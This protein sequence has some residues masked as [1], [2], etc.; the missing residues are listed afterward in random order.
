MLAR[1]R[2]LVTPLA[3]VAAVILVYMENPWFYPKAG[4]TENQVAVRIPLIA[5]ADTMLTLT[6]TAPSG[7]AVS[8]ATFYYGG[9]LANVDTAVYPEGTFDVMVANPTTD[10][11][12]VNIVSGGTGG[13]DVTVI[14]TTSQPVPI[15]GVQ[16][17]GGTA[18]SITPGDTSGTP[19]YVQ[20][21]GGTLSSVTM[22]GDV[23]GQSNSATVVG[24]EGKLINGAATTAGQV[25]VYTGSL[26]T[27][28]ASTGYVAS[29]G[30]IVMDN[31]PTITTP[32]LSGNT[33]AGTINSTTI[34]S[35]STLI[36]TGNIA[37]NAV[38]TFNGGTTGLT[39]STATKGD[40]TLGGT[41][42]SANGGTGISTVTTG[43]LLAGSSGSWTSLPIGSAGQ[44]LTVNGAGTSPQWQAP[45]L[46]YVQASLS[47]N[48]AVTTTF[49]ATGLSISLTAGTWL[50]TVNAVLSTTTAGGCTIS[51]GPNSASATGAYCGFY[52][53]GSTTALLALS[54]TRVIVLASTTTVYL[55]AGYYIAGAGNLEAISGPLGVPNATELVAVRI[56]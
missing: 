23:T 48:V 33:T 16:G 46:S 56:A 19:L 29:T 54:A 20:V 17:S 49:A 32:T 44:V 38:T 31:S 42:V 36:T 28:T 4:T 50:V 39:P 40:V 13:G 27:N 11:V 18:V 3:L 8:N 10:P 55:N 41:L 22:G 9:D 7:E 35:S 45:A 15:K 6:V 1:Y 47:S 26:W 12:N 53:T 2:N 51:I 43:S 52:P 14:N 25:L 24:L 34:P 37:S 30:K 21:V 5:S